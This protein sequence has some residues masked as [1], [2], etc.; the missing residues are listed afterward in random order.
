M[1]FYWIYSCFIYIMGK[2]AKDILP[3]YRIHKW[4]IKKVLTKVILIKKKIVNC[5][6][7]NKPEKEKESKQKPTK[8]SATRR[9]QLCLLSKQEI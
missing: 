6:F 4:G 2:N 1:Y 5:V 8:L 9:K 3:I 7:F